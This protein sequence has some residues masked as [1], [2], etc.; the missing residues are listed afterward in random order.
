MDKIQENGLRDLLK[1]GFIKH[2]EPK[3]EDCVHNR[4]SDCNGT[5]VKKDGTKCIHFISCPC[6]K[7]NT[8]TF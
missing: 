8:L 3:E 5:G 2:Q 1:N 4:C 7:C 6:P